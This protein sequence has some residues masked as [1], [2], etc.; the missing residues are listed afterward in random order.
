MNKS[1]RVERS[2]KIIDKIIQ[3]VP[4]SGNFYVEH[5]KAENYFIVRRGKKQTINMTIRLSS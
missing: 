4:A 2:K 5:N 1:E 3:K